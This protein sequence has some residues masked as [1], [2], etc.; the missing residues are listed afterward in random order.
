[1]KGFSSFEEEMR[2]VCDAIAARTDSATPGASICIVARCRALL[3][4]VAA[5]LS[6]AGI[7]HVFLKTD[8]PDDGRCGVRLGTMHRVKGLEFETVIAV[9][10]GADQYPALPEGDLD[11]VARRT[12]ETQERSLLYV[13]LTRARNEALV[14]YHGKA[15]EVVA[16]PH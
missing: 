3:V 10:M 14:T 6:E 12:F 4:Q 13:T 9:G 11:P 5:S 15:S 8:N 16:S 7:E 1:V 2:F